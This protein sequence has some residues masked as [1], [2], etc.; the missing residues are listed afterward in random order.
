MKPLFYIFSLFPKN[1]F[2]YFVDIYL[3]FRLYKFFAS[4]KITKINIKIAFPELTEFDVNLISKL[5]LRESFISAYET[6]FSWGR[7]PSNSNTM[8]FKIENNFLLHNLITKNEGLLA[9]AIHNRSVDMLLT[10]MNSQVQTTSLY[11]ELKNQHIERYVKRKRELNGSKCYKTSIAGVRKI[12]KALLDKRT[13]CFAADQVPKRG[14]GE[15][16]NFFNKEAY[17]TTLVQSLAAKTHA[18]VIYFFISSDINNFLYISL[19]QCNNAIYDDSKSQLLL[20]N[21]IE[22][23]IR[24]RPTDYSWEYKRFKRNKTDSRDPY[25]NI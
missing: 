21:D 16:I 15:Y 14:L 3:Y 24:I 1:M 4:Y 22:N 20:N 11:K 25:I 8:I 5:S 9:V 6:L 7:S 12:Y 23:I 19:K 17:T 2:I 10:W 18:P 13:V